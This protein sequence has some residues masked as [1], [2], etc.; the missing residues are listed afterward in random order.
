MIEELPLTILTL[1]NGHYPS[2]E[3]NSLY[4]HPGSFSVDY[5]GVVVGK[6]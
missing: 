4:F 1:D 2:P 5:E 6:G 3:K